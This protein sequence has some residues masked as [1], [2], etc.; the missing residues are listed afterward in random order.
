MFQTWPGLE[1][2]LAALTISFD[3]FHVLAIIA[4][5]DSS[6]LAVG[7][8]AVWLAGFWLAGWLAG[9]LAWPFSF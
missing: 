5:I 9:W 2:Q 8:L 1:G 6:M 7:W 3:R 4:I